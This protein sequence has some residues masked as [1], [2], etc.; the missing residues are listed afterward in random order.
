MVDSRHGFTPL[1]RQLL[2]FI[3][4]RVRTGE[5]RLLVL[6]TKADKLGKREAQ[7]AV[8][9]AQ[10]VLGDLVTE[11]SD[12]GVT[13]FSSLRRIGVEDVAESLKAWMAPKGETP[14]TTDPQW[15]SFAQVATARHAASVKIATCCAGLVL[16][17][18]E[19]QARQ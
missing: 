12:I 10:E 17:R 5:V 8:V 7:A 4:Q 13:L 3:A 19:S 9:S 1:D 11:N 2:D 18:S 16:T 15:P 6:L 14:D